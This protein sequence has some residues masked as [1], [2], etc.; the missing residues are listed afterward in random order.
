MENNSVEKLKEIWI[1]TV[2]ETVAEL[3]NDFS[4]AVSKNGNQVDTLHLAGYTM[5]NV[6]TIA[7]FKK[8]LFKKLD[9]NED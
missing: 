9:I 7:T 3:E 1:E 8:N 2:V 5:Q 6:M 4:N